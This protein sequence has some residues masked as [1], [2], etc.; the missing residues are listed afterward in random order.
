[1]GVAQRPLCWIGAVLSLLMTAASLIVVPP[2]QA[3]DVAAK[4][5]Q[6]GTR[7]FDVTATNSNLDPNDE[8]VEAVFTYGVRN[9]RGKLI[10]RKVDRWPY[11]DVG[12]CYCWGSMWDWNGKNSNGDPVPNGK[13]RTTV[14]VEWSDGSTATSNSVVDK[15][16]S[17]RRFRYGTVKAKGTNTTDRWCIRQKHGNCSFFRSYPELLITATY[18]QGFA[19]YRVLRPRNSHFVSKSVSWVIGTRGSVTW[20]RK[21]RVVRATVKADGRGGQRQAYIRSV[22][23][24][25]KKPYYTTKWSV[26]R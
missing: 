6:Y 23:V 1:M 18:A 25:Y 4:L 10:R 22:N 9:D 11:T 20:F 7:S 5:K 16:E 19:S 26:V 17:V 3:A 15:K 2:A 8:T 14:T 12:A 24:R 13:Y 21:G